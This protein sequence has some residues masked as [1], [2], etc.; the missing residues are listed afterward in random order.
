MRYGGGGIGT[1]GRRWLLP[2]LVA[3]GLSAAGVRVGIEA[4]AQSGTR[5][6]LIVADQSAFQQLATTQDVSVVHVLREA[7]GAGV[8]AVAVP[9]STLAGM[10]GQP[11]SGLDIVSGATWL[12][13]ART[14][15]LP[16]APF[17]TPAADT[18][19]LVA[20]AGLARWL[21]GALRSTFGGTIP[22]R[23]R[24]LG[25]LRV[26][27]IGAEEPMVANA[28]LG[29]APGAF[30]VARA[31]GLPVVP[32]P[33]QPF[34]GLRRG[35]V[36]RLYDGLASRIPVAAIVFAGP[37][38][39]PIPGGPAS[40]T[41]TAAALRGHHWPLGV[42]ELPGGGDL[43]PPGLRGL[44][45]A[46]PGAVTRVQ[47]VPALAQFTPT[48]TH[49]LAQ[50]VSANNVGL[51]YIRPVTLGS[52]PVQMTIR[53][54]TSLGAALRAERIV[55]ARVPWMPRAVR[56]PAWTGAVEALGAVAAVLWL[57]WL[58]APLSGGT[59]AATVA[60]VVAALVLVAVGTPADGVV[61][62]LAGL[63][64]FGLSA[65]WVLGTRRAASPQTRPW[66]GPPTTETRCSSGGEPVPTP[67]G[68]GH[69]PGGMRFGPAGTLASATAFWL[70]ATKVAL[71]WSAIAVAGGLYAAGCFASTGTLL[72]WR[73]YVDQAVETKLG[74][75][76]AALVLI[77]VT[78][79]GGLWAGLARLSREWGARPLAV[80]LTLRVGQVV[81][82]AA[83]LG[84][85]YVLHKHG[86]AIWVYGVRAPWQQA[87][88]AVWAV[89]PSQAVALLGFPAL[90]V[91]LWCGRR[92]HRATCLVALVLSAIGEAPLV[93]ALTQ[94]A[95][96]LGLSGAMIAWT[97][98]FG[99]A[100]GSVALGGCYA[101]EW[102]LH[103][104]RGR[105]VAEA[106]PSAGPEGDLLP[107]DKSRDLVFR[108]TANGSLTGG[109]TR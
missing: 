97:V 94:P 9:E 42:V 77:A 24:R 71:V 50:Q 8:G 49:R 101:L 90:F 44:A 35:A 93:T 80:R 67:D 104:W 58:V 26:A 55:P 17:S 47:S 37:V 48:E 27:Q 103:T 20:H 59:T 65:L 109:D 78:A 72:G 83:V 82:L 66:N 19:V 76:V 98:A 100:A 7:A 25:S 99:I 64:A 96:P 60:A 5:S 18:F 107:L 79:A 3:A 54:I 33:A 15:E 2:L 12:N 74:V 6:V 29:F 68:D 106:L 40:E 86:L 21:A 30:A 105:I 85:L 56:V 43:V 4:A 39:L 69:E 91:A 45:A 53:Y 38:W 10:A 32:R 46:L 57:W 28:P 62:T 95:A 92:G 31:A 84:L 102:A 41:T 70:D 36:S 51:L 63:A 1:N 87:M 108:A 52:H 34:T 73:G 14:G 13:S 23:W 11:G 89:P 16:A 61:A 81:M 75:V 88:T 22:I